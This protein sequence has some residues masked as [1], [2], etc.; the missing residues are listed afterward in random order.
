MRG[1]CQ[2]QRDAASARILKCPRGALSV[3]SCCWCQPAAR[4]KKKNGLK[5][6]N[7]SRTPLS[8]DMPACRREICIVP[9]LTIF[10]P[11]IP[12]RNPSPHNTSSSTM[13]EFHPVLARLRIAA[14]QSEYVLCLLSPPFTPY[15][16]LLVCLNN[17]CCSAE[18]LP[19][20]PRPRMASFAQDGVKSL[21]SRIPPEHVG[22]ARRA[23]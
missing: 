15:A 11:K 8:G 10:A 13:D 5:Y 23:L 17:R 12:F 21:L 1:T 6:G 14:L 9:L 18:S 19:E 3:M 4:S 22:S 2:P 7:G 16:V 20:P